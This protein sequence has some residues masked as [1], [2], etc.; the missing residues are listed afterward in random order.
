LGAQDLRA[1]VEA[2]QELGP[3]YS[4]AVIDSF[5]EKLEARLDERVSA[6]LADLTPDR[7]RMATRLSKDQRRGLQIGAMIGIGALGVPVF[8]HFYTVT[9]YVVALTRDI[10]AVLLVASAGMCGAGIARLFHRER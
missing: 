10:F 1:A 6:R 8:L 4:D 2:H 5:L 7:K 3:E 9:S